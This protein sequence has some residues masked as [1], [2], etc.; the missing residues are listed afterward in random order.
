MADTLIW[1]SLSPTWNSAN[2]GGTLPGDDDIVRIPWWATIAPA[3]SLSQTGVLLAELEIERGC[4]INIGSPSNP[5]II[6]AVKLRDFGSG[7]VFHS[8]DAGLTTTSFIDKPGGV[9][10]GSG[11]QSLGT[12][13]RRGD[14]RLARSH[15]WVQT[16]VAP[17]GDALV[18]FEA[19]LGGTEEL[20]VDGGSVYGGCTFA[21]VNRGRFFA[22][23][24]TRIEMAGGYCAY[25]ST[26]TL[27]YAEI[28]GGTF[29]LKRIAMARTITAMEA[30]S[31]KNVLYDG[32]TVFTAAPIFWDE[33]AMEAA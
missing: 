31:R 1:Q 29:D 23:G 12:F 18:R 30:A 11:N 13:V 16:H 14:V 15:V 5:L 6:G 7:D 19:G 3:A 10:V 8:N 9:H 4:K 33:E 21:T 2:F 24:A 27:D 26:A 22:T 17:G 32:S 25:D 28:K 20:L